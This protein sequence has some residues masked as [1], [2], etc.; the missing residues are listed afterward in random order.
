LSKELTREGIDERKEPHGR[1]PS[2]APPGLV[3]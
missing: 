2:D 1:P 3:F